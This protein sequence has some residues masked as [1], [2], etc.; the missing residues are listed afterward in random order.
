MGLFS[1]IPRNKQRDAA[2]DAVVENIE[3]LTGQ[4][5]NNRALLVS[6]LVDLD[7][8]QKKALITSAKNKINTKNGLP[9]VGGRGIERPHSPVNVS[10]TGGFTFIALTW[11]RPTYKGHAYA[12]IWR[13]SD[14]IFANA[15]KVATE[16]TDIFSDSVNMGSSYYYWVRFV[17]KADMKGPTQG[18][19]GVFVV[20]QES[21]DAILAE[22][23]GQ[24]ESSH[25]GAFLTSEIGKIPDISQ[26]IVDVDAIALSA[27][28]DAQ[29]MKE[30]TDAMAL[31]LIDAA[32]IGDINWASN[33]TK[34]IDLESAVDGINATIALEFIT[35]TDANTAISTAGL[36]LQT[37][38]EESLGISISGDLANTYYTKSTADQAIALAD[39]AL[40][41]VIENPLGT[42]IGATLNND[43]YTSADTDSAISTY[44]NTLK[45]AIENPAGTSL[46]AT[47]TT[48]YYT[49]TAADQAISEAGLLLKAEIEDPNGTGMAADFVLNY[50]TKVD[51][52]KSVAK[53]LSQLSSEFDVGVHASLENAVAND[54]AADRQRASTAGITS[55]QQTLTDTQQALAES[56]T[57]LE[58]QFDASEASVIKLT[59]SIA[60]N[61]TATAQDLLQLDSSIG[62]VSADLERNYYTTV[63]ADSAISN[64][65]TQLKSDIE[66]PAGTSIGADLYNNYYTKTTTDS[67]IAFESTM[68]K[69]EI[70]DVNG[71]SIGAALQTLSQTVADNDGDVWALWGIKTTVA[72]LTSSIGLV[73]DGDN[74]IFA[75]KGAKFSVIT[76]QN[77]TVTTPVFSVVGGK[78]VMA[79][80]LIDDAYIKTLVT[81]DLISNRLLVGMEL[82]TPSI[83]YNPVTGMRSGNFSIDPAGN[84]E[85]KN[86]KIQGHIEAETGYFKGTVYAEQIVGDVF[87]ARR[88]KVPAAGHWTDHRYT[89]AGGTAF[90]PAPKRLLR[91]EMPAL[92]LARELT[93][94]NLAI[95][96]GGFSRYDYMGINGHI[97]ARDVSGNVLIKWKIGHDILTSS[98]A[99]TWRP[100]A[101]EST[102]LHTKGGTS[103]IIDVPRLSA[104]PLAANSTIIEFW[105]VAMSQFAPSGGYWDHYDVSAGVHSGLIDLGIDYVDVH[106]SI[107]GVSSGVTF[108]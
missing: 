44:G 25:L 9:I 76:D 61:I 67:A 105:F 79:S 36:T 32:L 29:A 85:V 72:G 80:A 107:V 12:E 69:S 81:D 100:N 104:I 101:G 10:G 7:A 21:A 8:M 5:G 27:K 91:V 103:I 98:S 54:I 48:N 93:F 64:A 35:K 45:T 22:L 56:F 94:E 73:N 96:F 46:G 92:P 87:N 13:S 108:T 66:N 17:N 97:E 90:P 62:N 42:S 2:Q 47:L 52:D 33:T 4:R 106:S 37:Q 43:Y 26:S 20:T 75:V 57:L 39:T 99:G 70:E 102:E 38:I 86:A 68:L 74:P 49:K 71:T 53:S 41:A 83:N 30:N 51:A 82:A 23:G 59:Q 3:I 78:T 1:G 55:Q 18:A 89:P 31:R 88:I 15:V 6:D 28:A 60:T 65:T 34:L 11:D 77:P 14:N 95:G 58:S 84:M 50:Y 24:I 63:A 16:V 19:N 40:K